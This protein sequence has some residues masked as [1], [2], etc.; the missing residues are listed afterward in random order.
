MKL[1]YGSLIPP[2][3]ISLNKCILYLAYAWFSEAEIII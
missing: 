1:V 3:E 2:P